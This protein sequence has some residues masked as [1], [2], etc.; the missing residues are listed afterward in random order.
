MTQKNHSDKF[1]DL[2]E[3]AE[4]GPREALAAREKALAE[5]LQTTRALRE[6]EE[7]YRLLSEASFE[8]VAIHKAGVLFEANEQYFEMFGYEKE[9]LLG[10][11]VMPLTVAPESMKL[12]EKQIDLGSLEIYEAI[13]LKKNG[14][15]FPIE[16]RARE[17][18]YQGRAMRV[19][20]IRDITE[21]VRTEALRRQ[22]EEALRESKLLLNV[23]GQMAKVGGWELDTETLEVSWTEQTCHIHQVPLDYK[24]PLEEAINFFHPKDRAKLTD[25][26]QRALDYGEPYDMQ[27][28]LITAKGKQLWTRTICRP[29]VVDGKIVKLAGTFQDITE[30]VRAEALRQQ[31]EKELQEERNR[32]QAILS[33]SQ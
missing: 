20:I 25:A 17:M 7:R 9:E 26:I 6:S 8:A 19:A 5:A 12:L 28:R 33:R 4:G 31:A 30:R 23:T 15:K 3:R 29:K 2:D 22:A 32:L 10:K 1:T 16:I 27:V 21:R 14:T 11:Q 18:D 13:G 24:P